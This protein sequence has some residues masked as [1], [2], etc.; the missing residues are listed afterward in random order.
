MERVDNSN[1]DRLQRF[2]NETQQSGWSRKMRE[3]RS[4]GRVLLL[5]QAQIKRRKMRRQ[6]SV[7]EDESQQ[8]IDPKMYK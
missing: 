2:V 6:I 5:S 4:K 3:E 8:R 7:E 1:F